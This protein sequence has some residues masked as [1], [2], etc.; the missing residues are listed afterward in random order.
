[1]TAPRKGNAPELAGGRGA[2]KQEKAGFAAD[3]AENAAETQGQ[4]PDVDLQSWAAM[5]GK[6]SRDRRQKRGWKR[7]AK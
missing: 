7:G 1:M 6:P 2:K 5:G 3:I 4:K